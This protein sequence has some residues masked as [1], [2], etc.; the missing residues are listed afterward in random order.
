[1][2]AF[3]TILAADVPA[4]ELVEDGRA[5]TREAIRHT[6]TSGAVRD[7]IARLS[8]ATITRDSSGIA[9]R[10]W[11]RVSATVAPSRPASIVIHAPAPVSWAEYVK[12]LDLPT[13]LAGVEPNAVLLVPVSFTAGGTTMGTVY[14]QFTVR[15]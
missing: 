10:I 4:S 6:L 12:Q 14:Y 5:S 7:E 9:A 11:T 1:M 2:S 8:G 15:A 13:F 3:S